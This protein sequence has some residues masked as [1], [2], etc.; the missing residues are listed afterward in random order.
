MLVNIACRAT[1]EKKL[2]KLQSLVQADD[3]SLYWNF[4]PTYFQNNIYIYIEK[5]KA[6][7]FLYF[8]A[9]IIILIWGCWKVTLFCSNFKVAPVQHISIKRKL[10]FWIQSLLCSLRDGWF[11]SRPRISFFFQNSPKFRWSNGNLFLC[12]IIL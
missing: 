1:Y 5:T 9:M 11:K 3:V 12:R 10:W 2:K 8:W 6:K 7:L 4:F